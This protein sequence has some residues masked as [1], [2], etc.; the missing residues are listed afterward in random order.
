MSSFET[1]LGCVLMAIG[2]TVAAL[3]AA[4]KC[5]NRK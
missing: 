5:K 3:I 4:I 1:L 2:I